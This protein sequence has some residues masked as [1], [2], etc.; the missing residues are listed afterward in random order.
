MINKMIIQVDK[1]ERYDESYDEYEYVIEDEL[2]STV[3]DNI[4]S[5]NVHTI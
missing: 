3:L 1:L 5:S 2:V 4:A